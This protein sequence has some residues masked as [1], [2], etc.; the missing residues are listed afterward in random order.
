LA[1][2]AAI[3]IGIAGTTTVALYAR[4]ADARAL[5]GQQ[6]VRVF[7]VTKEVPAGTTAEKAVADGLIQQELIARKA[8]PENAL[9]E[10]GGGYGQLVATAALQP[11]SLVLSPSFAAKAATEGTLGIPQGKFAVSVALDDPSRVGSFVTVGSHVAIFDTFNVTELVDTPE[12]PKGV[13]SDDS[14]DAT[15]LILPDIEVLAVGA[16]TV[17][18]SGQQK[19]KDTKDEADAGTASTGQNLVLITV[20]ATQAEAEKLIHVSRTGTLTFALLGPEATAALGSGVD[21]HHL[22]SDLLK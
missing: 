15:R 18:P 10:V 9:T 21:D 16:T 17:A 4:Q 8:V 20:A 12:P 3:L 6:A 2:I 11:G 7:V 14:W 22:F 13:K 19:K 1:V 5:A